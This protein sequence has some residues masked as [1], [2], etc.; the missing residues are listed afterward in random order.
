MRLVLPKSVG[1]LEMTPVNL[2]VSMVCSLHCISNGTFA[3]CSCIGDLLMS[4]AC[5]VK[6]EWL[7]NT[8]HR[9]LEGWV[10]SCTLTLWCCSE[11]IFYTF[12]ALS[13]L[14]MEPKIVFFRSLTAEFIIFSSGISISL[15]CLCWVFCKTSKGISPLCNCLSKVI[16]SKLFTCLFF[17]VFTEIKVIDL[18][19]NVHWPFVITNCFDDCGV[20]LKAR[21]LFLM[22]RKCL[23]SLFHVQ[24]IL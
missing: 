6:L 21:N 8:G 4:C 10:L 14:A 3:S 24:P 11:Y 23:P 22:V 20:I 16:S 9:G 13:T 7:G 18:P 1:D 5:V 19:C 17:G 2:L 15:G 12:S